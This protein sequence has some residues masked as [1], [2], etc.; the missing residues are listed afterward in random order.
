MSSWVP[1][2]KS[3]LAASHENAMQNPSDDGSVPL[4]RAHSRA[5]VGLAQR[6]KVAFRVCAGLFP[7][8]VIEVVDNDVEVERHGHSE[9][10]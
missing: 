8:D 3:C 5:K 9:D 6:L 1:C 2:R 10:F 7:R 4:Q